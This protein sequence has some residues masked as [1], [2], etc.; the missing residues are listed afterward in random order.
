MLASPMLVGGK[1]EREGKGENPFIPLPLNKSSWME[2][3]MLPGGVWERGKG[4]EESCPFRERKVRAFEIHGASP[5]YLKDLNTG[6]SNLFLLGISGASEWQGTLSWESTIFL[7]AC[8]FH[9]CMR[10]SRCWSWMLIR[11]LKHQDYYALGK[12]ADT[13]TTCK[14]KR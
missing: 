4:K 3:S 1:R 7:S 9:P 2:F 5:L 8:Q 6:P 10:I 13:R 11:L 14:M 12:E